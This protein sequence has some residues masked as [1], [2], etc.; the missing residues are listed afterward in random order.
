MLLPLRPLVWVVSLILSVTAMFENYYRYIDIEDLWFAMAWTTW[1]ALLI[2]YH[3]RI[4]AVIHPVMLYAAIRV[5]WIVVLLI[6]I[7][8]SVG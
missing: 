2:G 3:P 4:P 8:Y 6:S 1:F 5:T 7:G